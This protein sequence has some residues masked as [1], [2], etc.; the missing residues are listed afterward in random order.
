[1]GALK[2]FTGTCDTK[3]TLRPA[4][5]LLYWQVPQVH[6]FLLPEIRGMALLADVNQCHTF[7][8][9][10]GFYL[11]ARN[12][13]ALVSSFLDIRG[14]FWNLGNWSFLWT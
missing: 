12:P 11:S 10:A 9:S 1:M 5:A 4:R 7:L 8:R 13:I 14:T 2:C 3:G 6:M